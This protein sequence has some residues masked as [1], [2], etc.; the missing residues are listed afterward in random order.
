MPVCVSCPVL[1]RVVTTYSIARVAGGVHWRRRDV[2]RAW[3]DGCDRFFVDPWAAAATPALQAQLRQ[4]RQSL[5]S[6]FT[7]PPRSAEQ[8]YVRCG[9]VEL[10]A[11]A[12]VGATSADCRVH[13]RGNCRTPLGGHCAN[14]HAWTLHHSPSSCVCCIGLV[15][16]SPIVGV[17]LSCERQRL[18]QG[19]HSVSREVGRIPLPPPPLPCAVQPQP[20]K[21]VSC[22]IQLSVGVCLGVLPVSA[23]VNWRQ[24]KRRE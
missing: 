24:W 2:R 4:H 8:L 19:V 16:G 13:L 17:V 18:L 5:R 12:A 3:R 11:A 9:C 15:V 7:R 6:P 22:E 10:C 21:R 23:D 14:R 1:R 20:L